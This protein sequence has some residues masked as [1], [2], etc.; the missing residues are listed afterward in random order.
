MNVAAP[1]CREFSTPPHAPLRPMLQNLSFKRKISLLV[2]CSLVCLSVYAGLC[3][4]QA[5][6]DITEGRKE[7]LRNAVQT[8]RNIVAGYQ[9]A[10]AAG[11]LSEADA[12]KAAH[13]A[14]K[15]ARYGSADG[16]TNYFYI[17][18]TDGI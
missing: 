1:A 4:V 13:D 7:A 11:T 2:L 16:K 8:A 14:V 12:K 3:I 15:Y 5:R 6:N 10:A 18:T 17:V 9:A